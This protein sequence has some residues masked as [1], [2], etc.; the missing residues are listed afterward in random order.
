MNKYISKE[1]AGNSYIGSFIKA[2]YNHKDI[3]IF[4]AVTGKSYIL[5][6]DND[7]YKSRDINN[8]IEVL[9]EEELFNITLLVVDFQ[10]NYKILN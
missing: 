3:E 6:Y 7:F 8:N 10:A 9:T 1:Q 4:N 5:F 2:V